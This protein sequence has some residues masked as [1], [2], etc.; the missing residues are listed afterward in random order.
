MNKKCLCLIIIAFLGFSI[1][2][3]FLLEWLYVLGQDY[4]L[5]TTCYE[6]NDILSYSATVISTGIAIIA[7]VI[8]LETPKPHFAIKHAITE[9]EEGIAVFI[10]LYNTGTNDF[11]IQNFDLCDKKHHKFASISECAPF[12][13]KS[14]SSKAFIISVDKLKRYLKAITKTYDGRN[15]EYAIRLSINKTL[16]INA[17]E[18][19]YYLSL[20]GVNNG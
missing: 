17:G 4:P 11:E 19:G 20:G 3:P 12:T 6:P 2:Y 13:I 7:M 1:A 18:L 16:Y 15:A 10:E 14:N 8:A 9:N 5:I